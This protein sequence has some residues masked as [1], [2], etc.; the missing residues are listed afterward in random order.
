MLSLSLIARCPHTSQIGTISFADR[1][2]IGGRLGRFRAG[3]GICI[4]QGVP[5]PNHE[6]W[7]LD[8]LSLGITPQEAIIS[9]TLRDKLKARRQVLLLG[10]DGH[11]AAYDGKKIPHQAKQL[12]SENC[13]A[14]GTGLADTGPVDTLLQAFLETGRADLPLESRL[15]GALEAAHHS[16]RPIRG[17]P[18]SAALKIFAQSGS[19][20]LD[21]RI[22]SSSSPLADL[23]RL[24]DTSH[25]KWT[26]FVPPVVQ[27]QRLEKPH[28]A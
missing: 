5:N 8:L 13:V 18:Q 24:V 15:L 4:V 19:A 25:N 6:R 11:A 9:S 3:T 7:A 12:V 21:L 10:C 16:S 1:R 23:R 26:A 22:D 2:A 28:A 20:V 14:G 27:T 17:E